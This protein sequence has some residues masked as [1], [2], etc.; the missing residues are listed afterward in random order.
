M[1]TKLEILVTATVISFI[2]LV[3]AIHFPGQISKA[4]I[5]PLQTYT[6]PQERF[7][8]Q[9]PS[10]WEIAPR[11]SNFPYYG[12]TTAIVFKPIDEP[13]SP[14]NEVLFS[15][16][17]ND[18]KRSLNKTVSETTEFLNQIVSDKIA[19][20]QDPLSIYGDLNVE[21][22]KN[23]KTTVDGNPAEELTFLTHSL[24][25]FDMDTYVIKGDILYQ[26]IFMSPQ[27]KSPET[28]PVVQQMIKSFK[29][30]T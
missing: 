30:T 27:L 11:N 19:S 1:H 3:I 9:Y 25:T 5:N 26:L 18:V 4:Q 12:D 23:N 21:I 6:D 15:I 16:T 17:L 14:L 28:F 8:L 2:L 20:F 7:T 24:G 10:T 29:F 22:L 13:V